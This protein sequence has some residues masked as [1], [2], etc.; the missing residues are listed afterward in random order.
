MKL[1]G[2]I[3]RK[4]M[5]VQVSRLLASRSWLREERTKLEEQLQHLPPKK[6]KKE[7][8]LRLGTRGF[9]YLTKRIPTQERQKEGDEV[10]ESTY[11]NLLIIRN[12]EKEMEEL[13]NSDSGIS[14]KAY[15]ALKRLNKKAQKII[16]AFEAEKESERKEREKKLYG[17]H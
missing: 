15:A 8:S 16:A 1:I 6:K 3:I 4:L 12:I 2:W 7:T 17:K 14:W 5:E 13:L 11:K 10:R 9:G